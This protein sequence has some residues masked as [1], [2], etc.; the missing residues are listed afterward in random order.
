MISK[1]H[2]VAIL[3]FSA[4]VYYGACGMKGVEYYQPK[5]LATH[6]TGDNFVGSLTCMEC[7]EEIYNTHINTAHYN[8]SAI[9]NSDNIMGSFDAGSNM[10]S[11]PDFDLEMVDKGK[12]Q[13]QI[14]KSKKV[15]DQ[16]AVQKI[17][18][19]VGSGVK[20]QSFLNWEGDKLT[21]L[22]TSYYPP[23]DSWIN[24]PGFPDHIIERPIRDGC[25]KCHVTHATNLDFSGKGNRYDQEKMIYGVDC[26]KCH[27]PAEKHVVFHR[28]N[29]EVTAARF[30]LKLDTL[31]RQLR[32]DAC[33]QC[34]SGPR[35]AIIKGTAFSYL[36]GER[37]DEYARNYYTGQK[38]NEL[39]VH[40]NQY[41][42]LTSSE[43]FI[44]SPQMDCG[45]CHDPHTNQRGD[46]AYFN[47][48]C[49]SCHSTNSTTCSE[50]TASLAEMNDNCISCHMPTVASKT[51][52]VKLAAEEEETGVSIRTHLIGIYSADA[53]NQSSQIDSGSVEKILE[54]IDS[55]E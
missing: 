45:T 22:Q 36:V 28:E 39:D 55:S 6:S 16:K 24:S 17:D 21:Q 25:L 9:A 50:D 27:Q 52:S 2:L 3:I 19:V 34:H 51:M 7:H 30:M 20:G 40:G 33:A 4:I 1:K 23:T 37:L 18:I 13:Y 35:D 11:L 42:L 10:I 48:K 54:F 14:V 26:E 47:Q 8:T 32:L 46:T 43:C 38:R 12:T 49:E 15:K 53:Q 41:G 29:P 31:S 5:A 44:N